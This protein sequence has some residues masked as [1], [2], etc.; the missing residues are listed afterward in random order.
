MHSEQFHG[1]CRRSGAK[2][3]A[4]HQTRS[5]QTCGAGA[6]IRDAIP[7]V[8]LCEFECIKFAR[9]NDISVIDSNWT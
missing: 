9:Q 1:L 2:M 3:V 6:Y 5:S 8:Q 4:A 7:Y